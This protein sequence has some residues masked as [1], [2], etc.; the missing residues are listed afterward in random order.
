[1]DMNILLQIT[2]VSLL[3]FPVIAL[4]VFNLLPKKAGLR[5]LPHTAATVSGLQL[6]SGVYLLCN[7]LF[8]NNDSINFSLFWTMNIAGGT[9][10]F[11]IDI[12]A[13]VALLA[14][15]VIS[16]VVSVMSFSAKSTLGDN[17]SGLFNVLMLSIACMNGIALS[18][19]MFS[20]YLFMEAVTICLFALMSFGA[21]FKAV[22]KKLVLSVTSSVLILSGMAFIYLNTHTF[23]FSGISAVVS[24]PQLIDQP[25]LLTIAYILL[26][27]GICI[28]TGLSPFHTWLSHAYDKAPDK[29]LPLLNIMI[30]MT[31]AFILI[32]LFGIV[33]PQAGAA[34]MTI[35][36]LGL[37]TIL[38]GSLIALGQK[39][40]RHI[41]AYS[42]ISELGYIALGIACASPL[43]VIAALVHLFNHTVS[44]SS[45]LINTLAIEGQ[46]GTRDTSMIAGSVSKIPV[47]RD[48]LT[49]TVLS[50]AGIPPLSGFWSK[51]LI[52]IAVFQAGGIA[53]AAA[54]SL[55]SLL[56][57]A[58]CLRLLRRTSFDFTKA[59]QIRQKEPLGV[60]FSS[61][62]LS[63][64]TVVLGLVFP[65][66]II[67]LQSQGF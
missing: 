55:L 34:H 6:L 10:Y 51:L 61:A 43:G 7:L 11:S 3:V 54:V 62:F 27:T 49:V 4:A 13:V 58:Y 56:T 9:S 35:G 18:A 31:G 44:H 2:V 52:I 36:V 48:S 5:L 42:E 45:L 17:L 25:L 66:F 21:D 67:Y 64:L 15:A 1:M 60:S 32:R 23:S 41:I 33:F 39:D 46:T 53:T 20:M 47:I 19:N 22:F 29:V 28:K 16:L 26:L 37:L 65:L 12:Y 8:T 57:L 63:V 30:K 59:K 24:N 50:V 40:I 38:F 14:V